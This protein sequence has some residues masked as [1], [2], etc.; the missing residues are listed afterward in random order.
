MNTKIIDAEWEEIEIPE[1]VSA[2][3]PE[4]KKKRN[5]TVVEIVTVVGLSLIVSRILGFF[6][7]GF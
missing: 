3:L 2:P 6:V 5:K 4:K 7:Y 1:I